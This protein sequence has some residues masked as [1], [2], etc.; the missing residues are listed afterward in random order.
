[1]WNVLLDL[2]FTTR[3]EEK[4][5][6]TLSLESVEALLEPTVINVDDISITHLLPFKDAHVRA[7][8]HECKYYR[9]PRA[10]SILGT[11]LKEYLLEFLIEEHELQDT[12]C[13]LVP[14]P[15]SAARRKKRGYNQMELIVEAA[16]HNLPL[17]SARI[18]TKHI[19]T[20]SQ[21]KLKR[22]L[23][24]QNQENVFS[25]VSVLPHV[26]YILIDDVVTTGATM[27][28]AY[29]TI[30]DAGASRIVPISLA[31]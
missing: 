17:T 18:L 23:R 30:R 15:I 12:P 20:P 13:V 19:D 5:V 29:T 3:S 26:T 10:I 31:H 27:A 7:L 14:M 4:I 8:I 28:S 25:A 6:R 2:L 21:T 24:L 11:I 22:S 16:L 1:M 9:N